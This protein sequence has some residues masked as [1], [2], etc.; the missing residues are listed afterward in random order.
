MSTLSTRGTRQYTVEMEDDGG[1]TH[2]AVITIPPGTEAEQDAAAWEAAEEA[3]RDWVYDGDWGQEG[4]IVDVQYYW[5]DADSTTED[6]RRWVSV[7]IEPDHEALMRDA[8]A[9]PDCD[10]EW[11]REGEGGCTEN[12][13]VLSGGGST[14]IFSAHC[15]RCGL[16]RTE[17][18]YGIQRNPG[19]ADRVEYAMPNEEERG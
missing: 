4:A 16:H 14:L 1:S 15:T 6:V 18:R 12:P 2:S 9:D 13:G 8:G 11:T 5:E 3:A 7:V 10:H 19:Q 17:T